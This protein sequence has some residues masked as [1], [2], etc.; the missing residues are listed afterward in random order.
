MRTKQGLAAAKASGKKLGRKKGQKITSKYEPHREKIQEMLLKDI[1]I[2]SIHKII[3]F[4][5]YV[6][7]R[8]YILGD[9]DLDQIVTQN[10]RAY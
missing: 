5:T 1:S 9:K 10:K 7:L 8:S 3:E 2:T 6:G 4:G